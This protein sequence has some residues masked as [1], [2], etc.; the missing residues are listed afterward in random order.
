MHRA[1]SS[2]SGRGPCGTHVTYSVVVRR[3]VAV[4]FWQ[5]GRIGRAVCQ[6]VVAAAVSVSF[7]TIVPFDPHCSYNVF[8]TSKR[9]F[10]SMQQP[11]F[12]FHIKII[13]FLFLHVVFH[14]SSRVPPK[15]PFRRRCLWKISV[16]IFFC[17]SC[18]KRA[19]RPSWWSLAVKITCLTYCWTG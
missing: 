5:S 11:Q 14:K 10:V 9:F 12:F 13:A 18:T 16:L 1:T 17:F 4:M 3:A 15:K 19:Q 7:T 8:P 2:S 6:T